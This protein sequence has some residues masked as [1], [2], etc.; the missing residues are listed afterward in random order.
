L[1]QVLGAAT[2]TIRQSRQSTDQLGV[3]QCRRDHL[4]RQINPRGIKDDL[5]GATVALQINAW[6]SSLRKP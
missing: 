2:L 5:T 1:E 6:M 3:R 4:A